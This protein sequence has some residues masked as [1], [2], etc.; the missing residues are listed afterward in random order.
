ML[1][2]Q[3]ESLRSGLLAEVGQQ[4]YISAQDGLQP[5][6]NRAENGARAHHDAAHHSQGPEHAESIDFEL[7]GDHVMRHHSS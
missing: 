3:V 6:S 7:G 5:R 2:H 4:G 1:Q